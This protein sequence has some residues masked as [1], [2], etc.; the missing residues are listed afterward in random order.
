MLLCEESEHNQKE[1]I[2]VCFNINCQLKRACCLNCVENHSQ[3]KQELKTF[4][5]ISMWKKDIFSYY[6]LYQQQ[7]NQFVDQIKKTQKYLSIEIEK[8]Q[9]GI[10]NDEFERYMSSLLKLSQMTLLLNEIISNLATQMESMMQLFSTVNN[11]FKDRDYEKYSNQN[12]S[13]NTFQSRV[14]KDLKQLEQ[15]GQ[16]RNQLDILK[17]QKMKKYKYKDLLEKTQKLRKENDFDVHQYPINYKSSIENIQQFQTLILVGTQSSKKQ[18]LISLIINFYLEVEFQDPYRFEIVDDDIDLVK[19]DQNNEYQQMRVYYIPPQYGKSGLRIINTPDYSDDL[20]F[21]DQQIFNRIYNVI[22]NSVS[23]NQNILISFVIPQLVQIG[24]FFMLESIL[25]NFSNCLINNIVFIFPDCSDDFPKQRDVLQLSTELIN[26]M[27][28]PVKKMIPTMN[29]SWYLKFNTSALFMERLSK[30]NE[31][32]WNMGKNSFQ[33]ILKN[34]LQNKLNMNK[35]NLIRNYYV[36]FLNYLSTPFI[37]SQLEFADLKQELQNQFKELYKRETFGLRE[38][39]FNIEKRENQIYQQIDKNSKQ[40]NHL[41]NEYIY[42]IKNGAKSSSIIEKI[43]KEHEQELNEVQNQIN[44]FEYLT[45]EIDLK[46]YKIGFEKF[47]DLFTRFINSIQE[48]LLQIYQEKRLFFKFNSLLISFN[49]YQSKYYEFL[50]TKEINLKQEGWEQ[51]VKLLSQKK[52]FFIYS[53]DYIKGSKSQSLEQL[54]K[55][56]AQYQF[57]RSKRSSYRY[58]KSNWKISIDNS[59]FH[60]KQEQIFFKEFKTYKFDQSIGHRISDD[61][62]RHFLS[63]I[64]NFRILGSMI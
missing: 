23:L 62:D 28:S 60:C 47:Y 54:L 49:P 14:Q 29:N 51:R 22:Q 34:Y 25:S 59:E 15:Q 1:I 26:G 56:W 52:D 16:F 38:F 11:Q 5:E 33:Q 40:W 13:N 30:E 45:E 57:P 46:T 44:T 42:K 12:Q 20:T 21:N 4:K 58:Q 37:Q 27:S 39:N 35:L 17:T 63:H 48:H 6:N 61:A 9:M 64:E 55:E 53:D 8:S 2:L 43:L 19:E 18:E 3:H 41:W 7:M 10:I 31:Y 50:I 36:Q 32:L 24:S